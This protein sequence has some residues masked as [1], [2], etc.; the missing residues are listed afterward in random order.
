MALS[1]QEHK[2]THNLEISLNAMLTCERGL[3]VADSV[4]NKDDSLYGSS[5]DG[6]FYNPE[7][8]Q[9]TFPA[10]SKNILNRYKVCKCDRCGKTC[11]SSSKLQRHYLTHT[12]QKPFGC[13]LCGKTFRQ[14]A[15]LKIHQLTHTEHSLCERPTCRVEAENL[16]SVVSHLGYCFE[17]KS[18]RPVVYSQTLSPLNLMATAKISPWAKR[19]AEWLRGIISVVFKIFKAPSKLEIHYLLHAGQ[20]PFACLVC[21]RTFMQTPCH[22]RNHHFIHIR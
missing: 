18:S 13:T 8:L 14:S 19:T 15:H 1:Q 20:K 11:P 2:E 22:L 21:G 17:F 9:C 6:F 16:N 3:N 10:F 5:D 12:G 7:V 4:H